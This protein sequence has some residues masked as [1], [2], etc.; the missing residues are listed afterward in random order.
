MAKKTFEQT[1]SKQKTV[2]AKVNGVNRVCR[3]VGMSPMGLLQTG[4]TGDEQLSAIDELMA[5]AH[6]TT[7][8]SESSF[9]QCRMGVRSWLSF[10]GINIPRPCTYGHLHGE[11]VDTHGDAA[12]VRM[13]NDE[14]AQANALLENPKQNCH[15]QKGESTLKFFQIRR[16][17]LRRQG[18]F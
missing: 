10:N 7:I 6:K 9:Y 2:H 4:Y 5:T 1:K 15:F 13:S 14:I 8:K 16:R 18:A 3:A 12:H 17:N 11:V